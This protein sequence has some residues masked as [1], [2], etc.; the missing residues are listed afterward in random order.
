MK[1]QDFLHQ[2]IPL[3]TSL[4]VEVRNVSTEEV[5]LFAPLA[6]NHNHLGSAFGGSISALLI[7]G[8]YT[9]LYHFMQKQG[10]SVHVIL[11]SCTTDYQRPVTEDLRIVSRSP[12]L[13]ERKR[14]LESYQRKG[15]GRIF[16]DSEI[17]TSKGISATFRGEFVVKSSESQ[18]LSSF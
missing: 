7:L 8:G 3:S 17:Q 5:E 1:L 12:M 10:F 2:Q 14:F 15:L 13:E 18:E 16:V 9:W 6:P 11:K 4:G